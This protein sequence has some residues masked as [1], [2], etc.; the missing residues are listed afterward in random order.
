MTRTWRLTSAGWAL[1]VVTSYRLLT[2]IAT[3]PYDGST[4]SLHQ[5]NTASSVFA[6]WDGQWYL[7]I[8]QHGYDP[9]FV[10]QSALGKQTSAAFPPALAALIATTHRLTGLDDTVAGL[11][12]GF[13]AL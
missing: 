8:A 1:L 2:L 5:R 6:W 4:T 10:Q 3:L 12:W 11:V 9:A 13:V 7:R